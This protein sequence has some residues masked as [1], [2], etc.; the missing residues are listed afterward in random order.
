MLL[1]LIDFTLDTSHHVPTYRF[2]IVAADV[3][4]GGI[5][6][7]V[8]STPHIELYAGHI[9]Y[10]VMEQYRGHRYAAQAVALLVPLAKVHGLNPLWIT[11]N[12]ENAAS[13]R[14]LEIAGAEYVETVD[15]PPSCFIHQVGNTQKCRYRLTV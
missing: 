8:G 6:F 12:P 13:R 9:G 1:E 7:R 10:N 15:V 4:V 11:C 5:R 3:R 14:T 2:H